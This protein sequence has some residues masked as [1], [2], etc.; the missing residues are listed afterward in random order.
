MQKLVVFSASVLKQI[1]PQMNEP[2]TSESDFF[3]A[4]NYTMSIG[5]FVNE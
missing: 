3:K 2:V 4:V 1:F 5:S